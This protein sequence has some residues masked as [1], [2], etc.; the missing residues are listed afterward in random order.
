MNI[1]RNLEKGSIIFMD[2]TGDKILEMTFFNDEFVWM[3]TGKKE[4]IVTKEDELFYDGLNNIMNNEYKFLYDELFK[5]TEDELIWFSD[6]PCDMEN[7][8]STDKINRLRIKKEG[9]VFKLRP[10]NPYFEKIGVNPDIYTITFTPGGNGHYAM[11]VRTRRY[12]QADIINIYLDLC[13]SKSLVL[14]KK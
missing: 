11:N 13:N 10:F 7:K 8:R 2:L 6:G 4:V 5:K 3:I 14:K 9:E 12:L 1:I